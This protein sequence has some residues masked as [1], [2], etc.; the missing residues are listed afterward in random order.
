[1]FLFLLCLFSVRFLYLCSRIL[2]EIYRGTLC[3]LKLLAACFS[4]SV[5]LG[6]GTA[7]PPL[8]VEGPSW[9]LCLPLGRR[10]SGDKWR[11]MRDGL[12][13]LWCWQGRLTPGTGKA[14]VNFIKLYLCAFLNGKLFSSLCCSDFSCVLLGGDRRNEL[15]TCVTPRRGISHMTV[16]T[17]FCSVEVKMDFFF[18]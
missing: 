15:A 5:P 12:E 2:G 8:N 16:A 14:L 17:H 3:I 6:R 1:M 4:T 11:K 10:T 18:F 9:C 13:T 7:V